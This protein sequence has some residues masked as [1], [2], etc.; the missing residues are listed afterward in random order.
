VTD[1]NLD[2]LAGAGFPVTKISADYFV[3]KEGETF[4]G[5]HLLL[6]LWGARNLTDTATVEAALRKAAEAAK[7]TV[8]HIHVH[9]FGTG[10]GVSG[11]AVLA[12]SHISIH[13]WP[14]REFAAL[15]IF[16]CGGC[17]PYEC[18]PILKRAFAPAR[19]EVSAHKRG[20][21]P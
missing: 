15:D 13:T 10:L 1:G 7:A 3:E 4:A 8:L 20:L 12:E 5:T 16:M 9:P 17:D 2:H 14:E 19:T 6:E 18:L 11:M 21:V